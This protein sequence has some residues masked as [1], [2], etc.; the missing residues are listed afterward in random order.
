MLKTITN[1]AVAATL[2]VSATPALAQH[3]KKHDKKADQTMTTPPASDAMTGDTTTSDQ[4]AP[5]PDVTPPADTT[6]TDTAPQPS[7]D[8]MGTQP[9]EGTEDSMQQPTPTPQSTPQ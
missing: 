4:M 5:A 2:I 8:D 6:S 1:A 7:T 9:S 3:H